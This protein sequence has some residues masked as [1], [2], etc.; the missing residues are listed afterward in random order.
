MNTF[1]K[2]YIYSNKFKAVIY[3]MIGVESTVGANQD[4]INQHLDKVILK[5]EMN[6]GTY[7][8]ILVWADKS[9]LMTDFWIFQSLESEAA[10]YTVDCRTF[11]NTTET[12]GEGLTASDGLIM[13]GR[14]AELEESIRKTGGNINDYLM[15]ERPILPDKLVSDKSI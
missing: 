3:P 5:N 10:G 13:L 15:A 12:K 4:S 11:R 9:D 2:P 1:Y 14:E 6:L 8:V 7:Q